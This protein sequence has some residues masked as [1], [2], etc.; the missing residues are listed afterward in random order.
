MRFILIASIVSLA[1]TAIVLTILLVK[2]L[3]NIEKL[4]ESKIELDRIKDEKDKL[5]SKFNAYTKPNLVNIYPE[6]Y[7]IISAWCKEAG[8]YQVAVKTKYD[9]KSDCYKLTLYTDRPGAFIGRAGSI[10][11]RYRKQLQEYKVVGR[12]IEQ[13]DIEE[14]SGIVNQNQVDIEDYYSSY[15]ANWFAYDRDSIRICKVKFNPVEKLPWK[16]SEN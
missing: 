10:I 4:Q 16:E 11:D 9:S 2:Y 5:E 13:V 1:V 6:I 7:N 12:I 3:Q 14:I 8:I 15:M